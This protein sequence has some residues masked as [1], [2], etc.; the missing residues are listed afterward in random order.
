MREVKFIV[1]AVA[2][3]ALLLTASACGGESA[4]P[5]TPNGP[6][7]SATAVSVAPS[8]PTVAPTPSPTRADAAVPTGFP[9]NPGQRTDLV[10]GNAGSRRIES[11]VGPSV[12][13]ASV[14]QA[15]D[16]PAHANASGWNCRVH[17]EYE[18]TPAVDWYVP[19]G[20]PVFATMDGGAILIVNT[21]D[22]AFDY[23]GVDREPYIGDPDRARAALNPF[24]G[25][26]GG[27]GVYVAVIG[28]EYRTD[29]GHLA[30]APTVSMVPEAA[31]TAPYSRSFDYASMF[32]T[33]QPFTFG[34][35]IAQWRVRK[36]D[37]IGYTGDAGYSEAPHLHYT[38]TRRS[39][40]E[41]LCP[42][43]E[44]GFTDGGWLAR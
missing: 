7:A 35:Q 10:T 21:V 20:T 13:E 38:I 12:R 11:G 30:I 6:T 36:G 23:Y 3:S 28:D 33:P 8:S 41:R 24:P 26:G 1:L 27:M 15:S 34:I 18:S 42:T 29:Y 4:A 16:D 14:V 22:N 44:P 17:V 31:F 25:P 5:S 40:G 32:A 37:I 2:V 9:L 19:D 39:S 43:R